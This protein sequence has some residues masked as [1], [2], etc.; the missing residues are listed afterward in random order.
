MNEKLTA[1]V[2]SLDDDAKEFFEERA[3]IVEF[4]G[5]YSRAEAEELAKELTEGYMSR[6]AL[7][8]MKDFSAKQQ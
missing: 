7:Q 1:W 2:D 5:G 6:R 8:L 4:D 3:A